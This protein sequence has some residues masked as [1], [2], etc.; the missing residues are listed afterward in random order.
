MV[1]DLIMLSIDMQFMLDK[2]TPFLGM[3]PKPPD[4]M[5]DTVIAKSVQNR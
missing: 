5:A 4:T 2:K 3:A 1:E